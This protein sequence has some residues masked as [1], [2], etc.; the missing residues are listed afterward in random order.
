MNKSRQCTEPCPDDILSKCSGEPS[1]RGCQNKPAASAHCDLSPRLEGISCIIRPGFIN[2]ATSHFNRIRQNRG[3]YMASD[4]K[5]SFLQKKKI[6]F[7]PQVSGSFGSAVNNVYPEKHKRSPR[8][9]LNSHPLR[10][11][12]GLL[13]KTSAFGKWRLFQ[14]GCIAH[15]ALLVCQLFAKS[16]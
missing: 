7:S 12:A 14:R 15:K 9:L 4:V 1:Q 5:T 6:W 3:I 16:V 13:F 11:R 2:T 10:R 8:N